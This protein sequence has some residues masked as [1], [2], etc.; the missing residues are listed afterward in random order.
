MA[1]AD[2]MIGGTY[3]ETGVGPQIPD[4]AGNLS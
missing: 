1:R 3:C 2:A 4:I